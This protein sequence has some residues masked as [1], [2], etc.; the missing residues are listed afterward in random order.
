VPV[1]HRISVSSVTGTGQGRDVEGN[2]VLQT[3]AW[4]DRTPESFVPGHLA[5]TTR[6]RSCRRLLLTGAYGGT[7]QHFMARH[8]ALDARRRERV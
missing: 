7:S 1:L 3:V 4:L 8:A 5:P 6:A 2:I